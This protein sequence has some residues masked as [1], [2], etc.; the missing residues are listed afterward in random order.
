MSTF[1]FKM[2]QSELMKQNEEVMKVPLAFGAQPDALNNEDKG[3]LHDACSKGDLNATKLL[4]NAGADVDVKSTNNS[5]PLLLAAEY[6]HQS[7][8]EELILHGADPTKR[9]NDGDSLVHVASLGGSLDILKFVLGLEGMSELISSKNN[10]GQIP[11]HSA[12]KKGNID[13]VELLLAQDTRQEEG[14][15]SCSLIDER[16]CQGRTPLYLAVEGGFPPVIDALIEAKADLDIQTNDGKTCLHLV[17]TLWSIPPNPDKKVQTTK[18]SEPSNHNSTPVLLAVEYSHQS[19]VE[20]LIAHG[21]DP[22]KRD[23]DGDS[24]VHVASLGGRSETLVYVL[25]LEGLLTLISSK[26][27]AG[28]LPLHSAGRKGNL[29]CIELLLA[30][31]VKQGKEEE[32]EGS[33]PLIDEQDCQGK[34]PLHLAIEGGFS[35]VIEALIEAGADL[36]IQCND[37]KTCL[38]LVVTLWG[39]P[40]HPDKKVQTTK[41]FEP[42]VS[43][44]PQYEPLA[45]NEKLLLYL[46][47]KGAICTTFDASGDTPI[48]CTNTRRLWQLVVSSSTCNHVAALL[49]KVVFGWLHGLTNPA[50]TSPTSVQA[51]EGTIT[52]TRRLFSPLSSRSIAAKSSLPA[53][54]Q[55]STQRFQYMNVDVDQPPV[56]KVAAEEEVVYVDIPPP[57]PSLAFKFSSPEGFLRE[58]PIYTPA[59][60]SLIEQMTR[61][62]ADNKI[63]HLYRHQPD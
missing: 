1:L 5:T 54:S 50:C 25:D 8:V 21:A 44:Y 55:R 40:E 15:D 58:L 53:L 4:I 61:G 49:F 52:S 17:V 11:L 34:T 51:A 37:G 19:C 41:G 22:M 32:G 57:L 35:P 31:R 18:G 30:R 23:N 59:M 6:G 63:W 45:D 2:H 20:K 24:L 7:C 62:Q 10:I 13:C 9:D 60:T 26:N 56:P 48:H 16:D 47:D 39:S 29:D 38:H 14:E 36:N 12:A 3:T 33:C 27:N 42:V 28:H 43:R 46:L